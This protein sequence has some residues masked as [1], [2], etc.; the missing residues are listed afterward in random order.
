MNRLTHINFKKS[1][2]TFIKIIIL[3]LSAVVVLNAA[4]IDADIMTE[5]EK[6]SVQLIDT[7]I[8]FDPEHPQVTYLK[9]T[10]NIINKHSVKTSDISFN[11]GGFRSEEDIKSIHI[12]KDDLVVFTDRFIVILDLLKGSEKKLFNRTSNQTISNN[13]K[14][15]A[16]SH[17]Q[18]SNLHQIQGTVILVIDIESLKEYPVYP[19]ASRITRS[20]YDNENIYVWED[21]PTKQHHALGPIIWSPDDQKLLF[22]CHHYK[23]YSRTVNS[24]IYQFIV[25]VDM[26]KGLSNLD[27]T[28]NEIMPN[29]Y[30][31]DDMKIKN[32]EFKKL[33]LAEPLVSWIDEDTITITSP[34]S[35]YWM[36]DKITLNLD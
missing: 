33:C 34:K 14:K 1:L 5:N 20:L 35:C 9:Y 11:V 6:Y 26:S 25:T 27:F 16:Y 30:L 36:K 2:S 21:D 28:H 10:L 24:E 22:L 8:S 18:F 19:E 13:K 23:T 7:K 29:M 32:G 31:K 3:T 12:A 15:I 17:T 4:A